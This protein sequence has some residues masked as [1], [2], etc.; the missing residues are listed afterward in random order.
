MKNTIRSKNRGVCRPARSILVNIL[1][2]ALATITVFPQ[3]FASPPVA[4]KELVG[5][6][7]IVSATIERDGKKEP[8]Y[9]PD[10]KG[11]L[12]FTEAGHYA[13]EVIRSDLP[14]FATGS[15]DSG[16]LEE[17]QAVV[18]GSIANY[19]K[20]AVEDGNLILFI[21]FATFPNW[22]GVRQERPMT[23]NGHQLS[24]KVLGS[25]SGGTAE[26]VWRRDK[27]IKP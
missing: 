16:T 6:W 1:A 7:S 26:F 12:I 20:Y 18:R 3:A 25:S 15:K 22:N 5:T 13:L 14:K 2:T 24:Y 21:E 27:V 4:A 9:G 17:N 19:G 23:L 10:P 11:I 8:F